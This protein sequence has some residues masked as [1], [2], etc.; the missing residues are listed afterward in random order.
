[1][2]ARSVEPDTGVGE[3][4]VDEGMAS[5][6]D[7]GGAPSPDGGD[8]GQR[9]PPADMNVGGP[10]QGNATPP[11]DAGMQQPSDAMVMTPDAFV[12]P[13]I[14]GPR[15]VIYTRD[16][17]IEQIIGQVQVASAGSLWSVM[18]DT[19]GSAQPLLQLDGAAALM[20]HLSPD[21]TQVV[22][23]SNRAHAGD[24]PRPLDLWVLDRT[25]MQLRQLT[26]LPG[27]AWTPAWSPDG[28]QVAFASTQA[29][30]NSDAVWNFDVWVVN[31]DGTGARPLYEGVGQ[32]EDPV[33]SVDGR[34]IYFMAEARI[35]G[36]FFQVWQVDLA[37]GAAPAG[38]VFDGAGNALCGED[39]SPSTDGTRLYFINRGNWYALVF[40]TGEV[41]R[42]GVL[43]EPWI[44]PEGRRYV[45][46][47]EG[48]IWMGHLD[49]TPAGPITDPAADPGSPDSFPRW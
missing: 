16:L 1:M 24:G 33:F 3:P 44:G 17:P 5:S 25:T 31:A 29:N 12:P 40:A 46:M 23:A 15:P 18:P 2:N 9:P 27:H 34:R 26:D 39:P 8:A 37:E 7:L 49:G 13:P 42:I 10:D 22:F 21:G 32:D 28:R 45:Y 47:N 36:C 6:P 48:A 41:E 11:N 4:D 14:E 20:P 35:D 30:P 19:P 38:P 43:I